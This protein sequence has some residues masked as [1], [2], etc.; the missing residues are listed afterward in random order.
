MAARQN[1][2][3]FLDGCKKNRRVF[4]VHTRKIHRVF[5][6]KVRRV[7]MD[8]CD[9]K[10]PSFSGSI[11]EKSPSIFDGCKKKSP[12]ILL[13]SSV[14]PKSPLWPE[15]F[16]HPYFYQSARPEL[17]EVMQRLEASCTVSSTWDADDILAAS[18]TRALATPWLVDEARAFVMARLREP[19]CVWYSSDGTEHRFKVT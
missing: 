2:R 17:L 15:A 8:G 12:S 11:H 16:V 10:S 14:G 13:Q 19:L 4:R 18:R 7:F 9:K 5:E 3:V 6:G 1:C